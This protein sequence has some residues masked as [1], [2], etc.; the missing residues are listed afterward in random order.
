MSNAHVIF[1]LMISITLKKPLLEKR[2]GKVLSYKPCNFKK[3]KESILRKGSLFII[4]CDFSQDS[5]FIS[6]LKDNPFEN[7]CCDS[8][9]SDES[10]TI[11]KPE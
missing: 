4:V 9:V 1:Q 6:T 2:T 5:V 11:K 10:N 3:N 8:Q 7:S